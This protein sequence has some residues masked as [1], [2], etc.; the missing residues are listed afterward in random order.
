[1]PEYSS[2]TITPADGVKTPAMNGSTSGNYTLS[3]LRDFILASK[4]QANGLASLDA[5]GKLPSSQLP[6]LADDVIVVAS[7]ASL[8]ATGTAGKIYITADNNKMYRWDPELTTPDYV[9]LSIDLSEY[10]KIV[11]IQDGN[12][13]AGVAVKAFQDAMGRAII[14]TYETKADASDLKSA[15]SGLQKQIDNITEAEDLLLTVDYKNGETAVPANVSEYAE[16]SVLKGVG[17]VAN[18]LIA[19]VVFA[20]TIGGVAF[21]STSEGYFTLSGTASNADQYPMKQITPTIGHK[22]LIANCF[23]QRRNG[24]SWIANLNSSDMSADVFDTT[25]W[26]SVDVCNTYAYVRLGTTY[27]VSK[28]YYPILRDLTVYFNGSIPSSAQTIDGIRQYYP[29]LLI[30]SDYNAGS[31]V[32]TTYSAV[33]SR[34]VNLFDGESQNGYYDISTGEF[35]SSAGSWKGNTNRMRVKP[36]EAYYVYIGS[37]STASIGYVLFYDIN[38][39]YISYT[40]T[41]KNNSFTTPANCAYVNFYANETY[42]DSDIQFCLDSYADKTTFHPYM[43]DTLT[44]PSPVTLKGAG[45]VAEEYYPE[46]GRVTHPLGSYTFTGQEEWKFYPAHDNR[47]Y[48]TIFA[49]QIKKIAISEVGNILLPSFVSK[50]ASVQYDQHPDYS[51][52]SDASGSLLIYVASWVGKTTAEVA[53]LMAGKTITFELATP[54]ADTYVDPIPDPF[55]QVEGG[56]TIE[57]VQSQSPKVDGAMAVTFTKKVSA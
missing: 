7:Y 8:P 9:E 15:I 46:S 24:S 3:A 36:N 20:T 16:V 1:M 51:V 38:G 53:S 35:V 33:E 19:P 26:N 18:Q 45:S 4:G 13:Q 56:G 52:A 21:N 28:K 29:E 48:V 40:A 37:S 54:S 55:T 17:R 39:N 22:Y 49:N 57:T 23:A 27:N 50:S 10:A 41:P 6:D 11:D 32:D 14:T 42:F 25:G 31:L 30:P 5:N 44:L 2:T 12:I 43:T 34:G 47:F